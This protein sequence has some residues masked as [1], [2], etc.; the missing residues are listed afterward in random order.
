GEGGEV[1]TSPAFEQRLGRWHASTCAM[2]FHGATDTVA[3]VGPS[4]ASRP[5]SFLSL[6]LWRVTGGAA[7]A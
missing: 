6:T 2:A 7:A 4:G 1:L 5:D 3:V